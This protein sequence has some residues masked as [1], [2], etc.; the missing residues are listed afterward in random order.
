MP[1][2]LSLVPLIALTLVIV[3]AGSAGVQSQASASA[4]QEADAFYQK[5]DWA[6]AAKAYRTLAESDPSNGHAWF[7]LG[8]SL[9]SLR[10]PPEAVEAYRTAIFAF[11]LVYCASILLPM[12]QTDPRDRAAKWLAI[13]APVP[14][15]IGFALPPWFLTPR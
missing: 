9:Q 14:T 10:R 5:R 7:R 11:T 15:R 3:S 13:H 2:R 8:M 1:R 12:S 6:N 4:A